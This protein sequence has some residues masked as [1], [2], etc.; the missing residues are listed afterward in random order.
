[1]VWECFYDSPWKKT[2]LRIAW[3]ISCLFQYFSEAFQLQFYPISEPLLD[4]PYTVTSTRSPIRPPDAMH[5]LDSTSLHIVQNCKQSFQ[6][7]AE[8]CQLSLMKINQNILWKSISHTNFISPSIISILAGPVSIPWI[9]TTGL[10]AEH[11]FRN[12]KNETSQLLSIFL[13]KIN[14]A[15]WALC[16]TCEVFFSQCWRLFL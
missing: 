1:M 16:D 6:D 9:K 11:T 8:I 12:T 2:T 5:F 10:Y 4:A 3:P 7:A 15:L 14:Y 13:L